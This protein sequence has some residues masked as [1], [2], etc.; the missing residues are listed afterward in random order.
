MHCHGMIRTRW[1]SLIRW[2]DREQNKRRWNFPTISPGANVYS[3]IS[4]Q[5]LLKNKSKHK[6]EEFKQRSV[7][8]T[9]QSLFR[10]RDCW[11]LTLIRKGNLR[12]T[13]SRHLQCTKLLKCPTWVNER[14]ATV[15][16]D[17]NRSVNLWN[18]LPIIFDTSMLRSLLQCKR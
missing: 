10:R 15:K 2:P 1:G 18:N 3:W 9:V 12:E 8:C 5:L 14:M 4:G 6:R 17:L 11:K 13:N 7:K 16:E